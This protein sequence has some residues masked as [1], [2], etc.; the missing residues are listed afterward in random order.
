MCQSVLLLNCKT[1][2]ANAL[3]VELT[4]KLC[5]GAIKSS[6]E[7]FKFITN[8]VPGNKFKAWVNGTSLLF[9][10]AH[11]DQIYQWFDDIY[12]V[13]EESTLRVLMQSKSDKERG[14]CC[15]AWSTHCAQRP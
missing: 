9:L 14:M 1:S 5:T 11:K 6:A 4:L 10:S 7:R 15:G 2:H 13:S 8:Q 3:F 12:A